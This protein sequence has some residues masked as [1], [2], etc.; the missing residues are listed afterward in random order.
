MGKFLK[1]LNDEK[2]QSTVMIAIVF[3]VIMGFTSLAVDIGLQKN[4]KAKLQTVADAAALAGAQLLPN[5][6]D[7]TNQAT[8]I[9]MQNGLSASNIQV[10]TPNNDDNSQLK[11]ICTEQIKYSFATVLG[12][13]NST[14][15]AKATAQKKDIT[16]AFEY[17]IL[18]DESATFNGSGMEV[19]GSIHSNNSF[20]LDGANHA[21]VD[22]NIE[23]VSDLTLNG[24]GVTIS[25]ICQGATVKASAT[26]MNKVVNES[27]KNIPMIDM[28]ETLINKAKL[29]GKVY[30]SS[31]TFTSKTIDV[32]QPIYINGSLN[33]T[34]C[35]FKGNGAI[36]VSGDI[37]LSGDNLTSL[38]SSVML[39]SLGG[40]IDVLENNT[41]TQ[42]ILYSP[43]GNIT[44]QKSQVIEGRI[45]AK[46]LTFN[47]SGATVKSSLNDLNSV[48]QTIVN[49]IQ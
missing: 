34:N 38:G 1:I 40:T 36:V 19:T 15:S 5:V 48:P 45:I 27:A 23:A 4:T 29:A 30:D 28:S 25:G 13:E 12:F 10:I 21:F 2:G 47:G 18:T 9:V 32:N 20:T 3:V 35:S 22:G 8:Q 11:V 7:A 6:A 42:A 46:S 44:L 14:V 37:N 33:L 31:Q 17:A 41:T 24:P 43:N 39:Y 49:L 16:G 26:M